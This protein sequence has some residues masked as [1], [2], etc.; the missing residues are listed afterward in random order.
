MFPGEQGTI[1][2]ADAKI[3]DADVVFKLFADPVRRGMVLAIARGGALPPS[4]IRAAVGKNL[5]STMKRLN[6]VRSSRLVSIAS[7]DSDKRLQMYSLVPS[8]QVVAEEGKRWLRFGFLDVP[9]SGV[10]PNSEWDEDSV[11]SALGHV[12]R[13]R[14]IVALALQKTPRAGSELTKP[15]QRK[16]EVTI[17]HLAHLRTR[18]FVID[19]ADERDARRSVYSLAPN[20][21]LKLTNEGVI[22][23]FGFCTV[24]L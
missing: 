3:W 15:A 4:R 8:V 24:R 21:P 10:P 12:A 7:D 19:Q 17:K 9:L 2:A 23:D 13:R 22:F 16:L 18:G 5:D 6:A 20:L 11:Y 14:L 1:N